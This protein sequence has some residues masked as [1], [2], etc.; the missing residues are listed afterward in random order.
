M[1][2]Q[3]NND[4]NDNKIS[5]NNDNNNN[6]NNN[7]NKITII[8]TITITITIITIITITTRITITMTTTITI[9]L[10]VTMTM[11]IIMLVQA[12]VGSEPRPMSE[13]L[14]ALDC[15]R[16]FCLFVSWHHCCNCHCHHCCSCC[17]CHCHRCCNCCNCHCDRSWEAELNGPMPLARPLCHLVPRTLWRSHSEIKLGAAT[18]DADMCD[19][20]RISQAARVTWNG[21]DAKSSGFSYR[22]VSHRLSSFAATQS[23]SGLVCGTLPLR[24]PWI[25]Q[26]DIVDIS[27]NRSQS[28]N[29]HTVDTTCCISPGAAY[30]FQAGLRLFY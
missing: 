24:P 23:V 9:T 25:S 15:F 16:R 28:A 26:V 17:N 11:T 20:S 2:M 30:I 3:N 21:K 18:C 12:A 6:N 4:N 14:E 5:N 29:C 27:A 10:T 22:V 13:I 7:N 19:A 8:T 1:T